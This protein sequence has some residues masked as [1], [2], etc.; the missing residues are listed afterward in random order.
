M[1]R[2]KDTK[3]FLIGLHKT[4]TT[5]I[6]HVFKNWGFSVGDQS[7]GE[8]LLHDWYL[9]RFDRI[10]AFARTAE[11]FQDTP[12]SLPY[13]YI[14]LDQHFPNAKFILSIRNTADEWYDSLIRFH[15]K[16]WSS[17]INNEPP[18]TDDLKRATYGYLGRAYH[19]NRMIF[20]SPETDIYNRNELVKYYQS[21]NYEVEQYFKHSQDRFIR[22]NLSDDLDLERLSS[23]CNKP[24]SKKK[25]P[26]LNK[27]T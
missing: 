7:K 21:H 8:N 5:S 27:S 25:F 3:Y 13:T 23:F 20:S 1:R 15:T 11:F 24:L 4:G 6:E 18:S 9:R 12:F 26:K 16:L 2:D 17:N 14:V 19:S 10:I 22:I